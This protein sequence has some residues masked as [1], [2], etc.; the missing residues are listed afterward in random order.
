MPELKTGSGEIIGEFFAKLEEYMGKSWVELVS[1]LFP[2]SQET[3]TYKW[4]GMPPAMRE[5]LGGRHAHGFRENGLTITNKTFEAT[6]ELMVDWLRRDKT[7]QWKIRIAELAQRAV[8]HWAKLLSTFIQ[9]GTGNTSGLCYDGQYFFDS[10]HSEGD[11]GTQLNLLAAA[12]VGA[13]DVATA[14][15]PTAIEAVKAILGV[16]GYMLSYKDDQGEPM[17]SEGKKFLIMTGVELWP[18]LC[19]AVVAPVVSSGETNVIR[20]LAKEGFEV[21]IVPNPRLSSFTDKF[22]IFRTDAPAAALIRQQEEAI[23]MNAIGAG[24]E[25]EFK[26]NRHLFGVKAIRNVGYGYWQ[27]AAHATLS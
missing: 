4:L 6:V 15:T 23:S 11:S 2:S 18:Y 13:L 12:Q 10:D 26:T 3:E 9:N 8:G 22:I 19:P 5:W 17:N 20:E 24:S 16:I 1:M 25:H 21:S 14:T 27:Y 7:G